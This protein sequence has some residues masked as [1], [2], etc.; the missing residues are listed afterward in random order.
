VAALFCSALQAQTS[1]YETE[2]NN[3]P[4]EA[5]RIAG[6]VTIMGTM[7]GND[8]DGFIW[9]V[10]DV[11][12]Q[13][14]WTLE[15][16]GIPGALTVVEVIRLEFADNG[17]DVASK[18]TLFTFGSR[19]GSQPALA[20][21][22][23][24]EPGEYVLGVAS[25]GGGDSPFRPEVKSLDFDED[26]GSA[27]AAAS[28]EAQ[29]GYRLVIKEGDKLYLNI[30]GDNATRETARELRLG[31]EISA[32]MATA[33][34]WFEIGVDEKAAGQRWDL[35]GQIPVGHEALTYLRDQD[36]Q[37]L[38]QHN[39]DR[40]GKFSYPD[41]GLAPGTY[42]LDIQGKQ[43]SAIRSVAFEAAGQRI[44]GAEAEPNDKWS[45]ANRADLGQPVT[46]RMGKKGESDYFLFNLDD[47]TTDQVLKLQLETG[48][49]QQ[50][51]LCLHDAKSKRIQCRSGKGMIELPDLV[52]T[53]GEWRFAAE[54]GPEGAEYRVTLTAQGPIRAGIE[55]E[56]NDTIDYASSI[57]SNNRIKGRFSGKEDDFY[58]VLV[59]DEPQ[60][61]RFQVIGDEIHELAYHGG[62]GI[63]DQRYRA[64]AG[65]RR[66]RLEN[67]FLLPG[68]H[69]VRVSGRDGGAYTLLARPIGSPDPNGEF[70][71][72][73]DTSRMQPLRIGQT[74]TG[75]LEDKADYDNYRFYL[76]HWDRIRLTIEPPADGEIFAHLYW[77]AK[78]FKRFNQPQ[79]GQKVTLEGLFPPGDYRLALNAKTTS[80]S[81]Y[82][83]SLE[84]L[85][86]FACPTDCEPNDNID[87]ANPIPAN[88][89][90]EG[91]ANEWR[92]ADWYALP[93]FNEPTEIT[94]ASET[95]RNISIEEREYNA[96][97][98]VTWDQEALL[99]R[100]T[101]PARTE[102]YFQI[103][104]RSEPPY[105]FE[106]NFP[107]GPTARPEPAELPLEI[108]LNLE[109]MEV[110]AYRHYG[111]Q[112]S[113][114][115]QLANSAAV[116]VTLGLEAVTSDYRWNIELDA[117][118]MTIPAGGSQAVPLVLHVPAD[119]WADWPVR[120]SA[121]ATNEAGA[122]VESFT[123]I[124]AGRETPPVSAVYGWTL[125]GE[126]RG[127][128]NVAW[129]AL[130]GGW[131]GK[132]DTA[133]GSGFPYLFDGMA[134][135][136]QGLQLRGVHNRETVNVLIELAGGEPVE[137]AGLALNEL[138]GPD[139]H[140]F[141]R[142]LDF[143]LS[144]DGVEFKPV[145]KGELLPIKAE[146]AVVLEQPV[147]ARF[148]RLQLKAAWD[149]SSGSSLGLGEIK[150][151][152]TP[153]TDITDGKGFNIADPML[154][155]HV[156]WSRPPI[157]TQVWDPV[158]LSNK[159]EWQ[160]LRNKPGQTQD[161]VIGFHHARAA[162][163]DRI[164][165]L[166]AENAEDDK[167]FRQV[168]LSA[169]TDSPVGPWETIGEWDLTTGESTA[170]FKLD[171]P[172]WARYVKFSA[173]GPNESDQA[174][175][176]AMI[177]IWERPSDDEY[178]SIL[179]EW[180]FASQAAIYEELHPLQVEK[181]FEAANHD[182][183]ARAADLGFN[184]LAGGQVV[185]G[186][187]ENWYRLSVPADENT[188]TIAIGGDPTVRTVIQLE[189]EAGEP[190]PTR[191]VDLESTPSLHILE[192]IVEPGSPYFMKIEEPPRNV[193]FLW[194]TSASIGAYLPVIYNSLIAYAEDVVPGQDAANLIP[195]GGKPLLRDWYG[196]PFILQTVLNDYPREES[197][198]EA[199]KTLQV[200]S[201]VLAPRAGT[202]AIVMVTDAATNRYSKVWEE[203]EKVR[204]RIFGL[205]VGSQVALCRY[206]AR[207]QD[208]MQ[209]WSRVNG[210]H[211]THLLS[212]GEM[213]VAFDRASTMLRR[214]AEYTIEVSSSYREAPGPGTLAVVSAGGA[215]DAGGAVEL[216]L[217]ASGSMLKRIEGKRRI[218]IAKEVLVE[219]VNHH[220]PA[221]TPV[222]LRVFG[223][224][225][226]GSCRT[227]LE[228][229]LK[230]LDPAGA[231]KTI[232]GVNAM[233]LAKTPIAD[234]L[235]KVESDLKNA[236]GPKAVVL[237]TDGEETCEGDAAK[238]IQRLRDK[239]LDITL[240]IV[241]F[242]IDD[243]EIESQF[244]AWSELGGGR[245][246]SA[247]NQEGLNESLQAALRIPYA[248]YDPGGMLAGEG[249]VN[250][251]PLEL[252]Q[253]FYRV[254][255]ATSPP[256]IFEK[257]E[258][259]GEERLTLEV[260]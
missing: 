188:L 248:V 193:A 233:N 44:E 33:A 22:L 107:G 252:E 165:W 76:S 243:A 67:L 78:T 4:A 160:R 71:P 111:Q 93:V 200:A 63:Q 85:E 39:T 213:E 26:S 2:P 59:T 38:S 158:L 204:P 240:N 149:G 16:N 83:L 109:T 86:R 163:I 144:M 174:E 183:K 91:R 203:F 146:Q 118:E 56:P 235:K 57:P 84:R 173:T 161:F 236:S 64:E 222:A 126:L 166:N 179:G 148:A 157:S 250:G 58:R 114:E 34:S 184:Q 82:K 181:P 187:H 228:I 13:Q 81:E 5:N 74:R 23:I 182:S 176:P 69:H 90:I 253:G 55:A 124:S 245:Y 32:F 15:L 135:E 154:G 1:L 219:A 192:A 152:T 89:I 153:G 80:E 101:I 75:L 131:A 68:I 178:H 50:M 260:N 225:E 133:I 217:D 247:R 79:A 94:V 196:E 186:K 40:Q 244:E 116:P 258:I 45:L 134:V 87:F 132:K 47:A 30:P 92:D 112:V 95:K 145:I 52:L 162:R 197:S 120:I 11:D 127:G 31:S 191:K 61:W 21:N 206:P 110:G 226:P 238:V 195:F 29:G 108:S 17:V 141:L 60:L 97:N 175:S 209:D 113:G 70:E 210:G 218:N 7:A 159:D 25:A 119:A 14:R 242:A 54:R 147:E 18:T 214:P 102:T 88:H 256:R 257:V 208:L 232:Q 65:Q 205:G 104:A 190:I 215:A 105:R 231:A 216:I 19:D 180:G 53:P 171:Q 129:G 20:E 151:I 155:G 164:E 199:E 227:D 207:E 77:D 237:V 125:P 202:K 96:K 167:K 220:I 201:E 121:R 239:G 229:A 27:S 128:L 48:A 234:S 103:A 221:G 100:G 36:G 169:S 259:P 137:V 255:V 170:V 246:F 136:K 156:V 42:Y 115:F 212:E 211:Y 140:Q 12:A 123:H 9:T 49:D 35:R 189:N 122:Q 72:N 41:L 177:R 198:S 24:F 10:S 106:V 230:P 43:D 62:A 241:G 46:G 117:K 138:G 168:S 3:T 251:E 143:A 194:D 150:V 8:Q 73:D 249:V 51:Q 28:E 130:G 98:L 37:V 224:K 185:L 139:A 142:N 223:H 172:V 99:W 66:V 6:E 254:V